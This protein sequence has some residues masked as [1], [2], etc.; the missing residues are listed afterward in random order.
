MEPGEMPY[1]KRRRSRTS[2][3]RTRTRSRPA[4]TN[5]PAG[6]QQGFALVAAILAL[7]ALTALAT[8][9]FLVS[10]TEFDVGTSHRSSV[11]AFYVAD[12]GQNEFLARNGVP[13]DSETYTYGADTADIRTRKLVDLA[14]GMSV[15]HVTTRSVHPELLGSHS[16]RRTGAVAVYTPFPMKTLG[17]FVAAN[18]LVKQGVSGTIDGNDAAT[19]GPCPYGV[20]NG[21]Q[22][23]VAGVAV[24]EGGY[25]QHGNN[26]KL[27][28]EG[29]PPVLE[30]DDALELL[31]ETEIDWA[32]LVTEDKV[33]P[34]YRIPGDAWPD[35][36]TMSPDEWPVIHITE[37]HFEL[38]PVHSGWGAIILDH[39][40]SIQGN[41]VWDGL[42]LAGGRLVSDGNQTIMGTMYTGMNRLLG[43][44]GLVDSEVGNGAKTFRYHSCNVEAAARSMGWLAAVPGTWY[45]TQ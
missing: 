26:K 41:F 19:P 23:T 22:P 24:P 33:E 4:G 30:M 39:D 17:A 15:F 21:N 44:T 29:D 37:P 3:T 40:V 10:N 25:V 2:R 32:G 42:I 18:G 20:G 9:G 8:A 6:S 5:G 35:F 34:D 43:E 38:R 36:S 27:V 12:A 1:A 31:Q 7:V 14:D 13:A 45:E 28:P 11:D 16:V